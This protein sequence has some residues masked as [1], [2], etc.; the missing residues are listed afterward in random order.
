M[1]IR[2]LIVDDEPD[3]EVLIAQKY[4]RKIKDGEFE[5]VF[6]RNGEEALTKLT[7]DPTLDVVMSDINM[8]VMDG[9]TLL[10][11]LQDIERTVKAVMI[12]AYGDMKN[13]R[14]AM[15]RGAY[16][17]LTKPIDFQDFEVTLHRTTKELQTINEGLKAREQLSAIRKELSVAA[18]LAK[19]QPQLSGAGYRVEQIFLIHKKTGLLLQHVMAQEAVI[20]D[21]DL[22]SGMLTAI[23][24]FVRDSFGSLSGQYELET[25]QVGDFNVRIAHGPQVF[26]GSVI[27]GFPP[28][29]IK[30][31]FQTAVEEIQRDFSDE[32]DAFNG[33]TTPFARSRT[34]LETCLGNSETVG[35]RRKHA[36]RRIDGDRRDIA[37]L[38]V[39]GDMHDK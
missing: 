6:A 12:S 38:G 14:T 23:Q 8:P 7:E 39:I 3:L 27:R 34:Y 26:L 37:R 18:I 29:H 4:R 16:D 1:P 13:I 36:D 32:L 9:L 28:S 31:V 11:K 35:E 22:V 21:A 33:D 2:A 19:Q 5:F 25:I 30:T 10:T 15:N 20:Q 17:F 24:D